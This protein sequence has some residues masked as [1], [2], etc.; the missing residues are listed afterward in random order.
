MSRK[1]LAGRHRPKLKFA[2]AGLALALA[3]A[4]GS[5]QAEGTAVAGLA[6][7]A[8][9][10]VLDRYGRVLRTSLS[11]DGTESQPVPLAQVS[12]WLI[13]ST[14]AIEDK[15]FFEHGGVD[16][17]AVA[18]ATVQNIRAGRI[19][20]GA[21]TLTEQLVRALQPRPRT[22][23]GKTKE[24]FSAL[25][26]EAKLSK[27]EI[28]E[29]YLNHAPYGNQAVG[30]E[31]AARDYFDV[32]ASSLSLAQAALLA[33]IPK[34]PL[35]YDPRHNLDRA[36]QRQSQ[37]FQALENG[38]WVD[39]E[40]LRLA[41]AEKIKIQSR[42]RAFEAPHFT[43][44]VLSQD[45]GQGPL[46][47]TLDGALQED[48]QALLREHVQSLADNHVENGA[49]VVLDNRSGDILAYVGSQNF[50]AGA[51]G[52]VD[53]AAALRQPGSALKPFLYGLAFERGYSPSDP[54]DD[55][56]YT[57]PDGYTPVNYDRSFHGRV[58]L[59]Q[60]LA[61]SYNVPAVRLT[62]KLGA[63]ALL[64]QLHLFGFASLDQDAGHYGLGLALG[65]GEV[66]LL[67]M[68][69]A[70]AALARGGLWMPARWKLSPDPGP[71]PL[72]VLSS[73]SAALVTDILSDNSARS[74]AFG[75]NSA[76]NLP[77]VLAAK[78]GTT[79]DYR[80]NWCVGYTPEWTVAV[81]VGNF[82]AEP[83]RHVS[84][85][86]G[87]GPLM[88]DAALRLYQDRPSSAFRLPST[89]RRVEVCADSGQL[90]TPAC[91]HT[92]LELF[93]A[94][95]LPHESCTLHGPALRTVQLKQRLEISYPLEGQVFKLDPFLDR[96]AQAIHLS[97]PVSPAGALQWTVDDKPV[98]LNAEGQA[99]WQLKPGRH[100][101]QVSVKV[102]ADWRR[103][104]V[105][106]FR[107]LK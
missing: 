79:K 87:A 43:Q 61:C 103:S 73:A 59:R 65:N 62:Q 60:A 28:L 89:L 80:D 26:L 46:R 83:M 64:R 1:C 78:T 2:K 25:R 54:I 92:R 27:E 53:G 63:E 101:T 21:S 37:V 76:L 47:T 16:A 34:S 31:A 24:A 57:A 58:S 96:G 93:A 42:P 17:Q 49:L 106:S 5:A 50:D 11:S 30:A 102:G 4:P 67:E 84:G 10:Q 56:P 45:N 86:T 9:R 66:T 20:S 100:E 36:L 105:V 88:H 81:W 68:A 91:P 38:G 95:K 40:S 94:W 72:R 7:P 70:Y 12:P 69:S 19:V 13:V 18:R 71:E 39:A 29:S 22:F 51:S 3:L 33:G 107:V 75:L 52:Q 99:W 82:N 85:V 55:A 32:P 23:W 44:W 6:P 90:R 15:R 97:C 41:R 77:F 48:L 74:P 98:P 35:H 14:L 8:S 104:R